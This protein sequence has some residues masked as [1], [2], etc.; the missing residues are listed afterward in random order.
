MSTTTIGHYLIL[1]LKPHNYVKQCYNISKVR[2]L[3][4]VGIY[5]TYLSFTFYTVS[6][7]YLI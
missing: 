5:T 2:L 6:E 3:K 7:L 4:Q 1:K